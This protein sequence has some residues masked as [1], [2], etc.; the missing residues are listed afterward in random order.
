MQGHM[1]IKESTDIYSVVSTGKLITTIEYLVHF[2][3]LVLKA[4]DQC[5]TPHSY[6]C[7][8]NNLT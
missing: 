6:V 4:V 3:G 7:S 1:D 8:Q 5:P 2:A